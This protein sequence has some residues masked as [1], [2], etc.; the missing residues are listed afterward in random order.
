MGNQEMFTP[1]ST[2]A[3]SAYKRVNI[4]TAVDHANPHQLVNLLFEALLQSMQMARA[5]MLRGDVEAKGRDIGKAVRIL[6]EGL[7]AGLDHERGGEMA[8]NLRAVYGYAARCLTLANLKN[9]VTQLDEALSLIA[10]VAD[11]WKQIAVVPSASG[12]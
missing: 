7:S 12:Q 2:R 10:P 9:D 5:A 11:A 6:E 4:E 1:V 8:A 3:A